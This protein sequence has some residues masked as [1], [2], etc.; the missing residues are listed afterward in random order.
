MVPKQEWN[1]QIVEKFRI[2]AEVLH[3]NPEGMIL[4]IKHTVFSIHKM[5]LE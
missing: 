1:A 5:D 4:L 2:L 3:T